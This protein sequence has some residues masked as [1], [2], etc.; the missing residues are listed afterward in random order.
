MIN[1]GWVEPTTRRE[2][3]QRLEMFREKTVNLPPARRGA[4][5]AKLDTMQARLRSGPDSELYGPNE[6]RLLIEMVE[7]IL[8]IQIPW[9]Y[10]WLIPLGTIMARVQY[11][12]GKIR[13]GEHDKRP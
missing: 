1:T 6:E 8:A 5:D 10:R 2:L 3:A 7:Q 9:Y 11:Q 4:I 12:W 13:K